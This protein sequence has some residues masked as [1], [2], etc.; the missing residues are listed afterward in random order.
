MVLGEYMSSQISVAQ[1][2][3]FFAR[4]I[5]ACLCGACIGIERSKRR[6]SLRQMA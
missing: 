6:K 5:A 4:V 1:D 2:L 3:E